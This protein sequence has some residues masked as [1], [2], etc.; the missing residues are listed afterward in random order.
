MIH[1]PIN[2][3][4]EQLRTYPEFKTSQVFYPGNAKG[5]IQAAL[6]NVDIES[7]LGNRFMALQKNDQAFSYH[8]SFEFIQ[9]CGWVKSKPTG[10]EAN[11]LPTSLV[12]M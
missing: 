8:R 4:K 10:V 5:P 11:L 1:N 7:L 12:K 2:Q 9:S 6:Q 3:Y